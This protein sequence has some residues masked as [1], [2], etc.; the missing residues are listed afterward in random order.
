MP[1]R[2]LSW[3]RFDFLGVKGQKSLVGEAQARV[4]VS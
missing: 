2:A 1:Y 3:G 4:P